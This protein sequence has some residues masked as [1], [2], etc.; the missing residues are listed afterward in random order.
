MAR[1]IHESTSHWR[2]LRGYNFADKVAQQNAI[3]LVEDRVHLKQRTKRAVRRERR[4]QY[5]KARGVSSLVSVEPITA[6]EVPVHVEQTQPLSHTDSGQSLLYHAVSAEDVRAFLGCLPPHVTEGIAGI[7]LCMGTVYMEESLEDDER[8]TLDRS[9]R[10]DPWF[11]RVSEE[12]FTGFYSPPVYG[13]FDPDSGRINLYAY[14]WNRAQTAGVPDRVIEF[15]FRLRCLAT[16]AHEVA[17]H[18]DFGRRVARGRWLCDF[19]D[20]Y[21]S[22]AE[23]MQLQWMRDFIFAYMLRRYAEEWCE[24]QAWVLHNG[25]A[26]I[27][28]KLLAGDPRTT[29]RDGSSGTRTNF[30]C[31]REA[32]EKLLESVITG[33]T[34]TESRLCY[35]LYLHFADDYTTS[36]QI[37]EKLLI[38]QP[39]N[40][41]ALSLHADILEHLRR[42]E[43]ALIYADRALSIEP[44]FYGAWRTKAM[45]AEN[46]R[47]WT[48]LLQI[49]EAWRPYFTDLNSYNFG[50]MC[51][52]KAVALYALGRVEEM[53]AAL[54]QAIPAD[55]EMTKAERRLENLLQR[56]K[57]RVKM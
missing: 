51:S 50:C 45:L 36:L 40:V 33:E 54:R 41:E 20:T 25:G 2:C 13:S 56:V 4:V 30:F 42:N 1:S 57:R 7:H 3:R 11:G 29:S 39:K 8:A 31:P 14:V 15:N 55:M 22:Y 18:F 24:L 9:I 37:T 49:C 32:M 48:G 26:E 21:E 16:L 47:D 17:H 10:C 28:L 35:A 38:E 27:S 53:E 43:E 34:N 44:G 12:V 19:V 23:N 6:R 52:Y 5:L 46:A